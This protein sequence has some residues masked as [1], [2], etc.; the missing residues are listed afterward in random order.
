VT[1]SLTLFAAVVLLAAGVYAQQLPAAPRRRPPAEA[2]AGSKLAACGRGAADRRHDCHIRGEAGIDQAW[3]VGDARLAGLR[4][5]RAAIEPA[6]D[7]CTRA[8]R[9]AVTPSATTTYTLTMA[10]S[11]ESVTVTV[12]GTKPV[13]A[14]RAAVQH[15]RE[16]PARQ[17]QAG[18]LRV[19]AFGAEVAVVEAPE[20][21]RRR[22]AP[23]GPQLKPGPRSTACSAVRRTPGAR[24][25]ACRCRRRMRLACRISSRSFRTRTT[26]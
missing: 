25:T 14:T 13:A 11:R 5:R 21:E 8:A 16:S 1:R 23:A 9:S 2:P 24:R 3:R 20:G 22:G 4:I 17:R 15:Q 18:L 6:S 10:I 26:W 7:A 12:A 19:F